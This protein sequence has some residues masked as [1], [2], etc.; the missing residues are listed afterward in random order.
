[1]AC[2]SCPS[3]KPSRS[4]QVRA[5]FSDMSLKQVDCKV[6]QAQHV[7]VVGQLMLLLQEALLCM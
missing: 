6:S 1:M 4:R 7:N 5:E 3:L 2:S